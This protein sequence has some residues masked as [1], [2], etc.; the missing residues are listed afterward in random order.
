MGLY[1]FTLFTMHHLE[2][3]ANNFLLLIMPKAKHRVSE[4]SYTVKPL[5]LKRHT[6][7]QIKHTRPGPSDMPQIELRVPYLLQK[8]PEWNNIMLI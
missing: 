1:L 3:F 4:P 2:V 8:I 5:I 6:V 7:F